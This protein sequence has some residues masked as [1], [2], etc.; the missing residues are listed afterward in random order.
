[1]TKNRTTLADVKRQLRAANE[2]AEADVRKPWWPVAARYDHD[3]AHVVIELRSGT[4]VG[5]PVA[6]V[7]ELKKATPVQLE[8]VQLIGDGLHW[9]ALDVDISIPGLLADMLGTTMFSRATGRKGGSVRSKAKATA[10][11][12]NGAKGGRPRKKSASA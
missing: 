12:V 8:E 7:K 1:V 4:S 5:V 6:K 3:A 2:A 9:E 10:A 11:R